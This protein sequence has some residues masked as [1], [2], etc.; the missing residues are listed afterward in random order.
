[1]AEMDVEKV[2][3]DRYRLRFRGNLM[4][5]NAQ[6]LLELL[7]W[8]QAHEQ[9]LINE[10]LDAMVHEALREDQHE[11]Q[12]EMRYCQHCGQFHPIAA[13]EFYCPLDPNRVE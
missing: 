5:V 12:P 1:M 8:L 11:Q 2:A 4:H 13:A 10:K 3:R 9:E 6:A 7:T